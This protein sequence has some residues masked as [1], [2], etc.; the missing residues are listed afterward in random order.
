VRPRADH[1]LTS[2][3]ARRLTPRDRVLCGVLFDH[4]VLTTEQVADL[5]FDNLG[6]PA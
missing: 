6:L 2:T 1:D 3:I 5:C 4:K